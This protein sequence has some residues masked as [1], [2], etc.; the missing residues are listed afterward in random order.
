MI[1]LVFRNPEGI[2]GYTEAE[3]FTEANEMIA[4]YTN[5]GYTLVRIMHE[6]VNTYYVVKSNDSIYIITPSKGIN[7]WFTELAHTLAFS[8]C[9]DEEVILIIYEGKE[10]HYVGWQPDMLYEFADEVGN[11]IW[12]NSFPQW[13]H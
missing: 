6:S 4:V 12:S 9:S 3:N 7:Q 10:I 5:K 8:D 1:G 2:E 13:D 11:I